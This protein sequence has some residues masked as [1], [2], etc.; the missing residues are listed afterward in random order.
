MIRRHR[1]SH[2]H[3]ETLQQDITGRY[4]LEVH[5]APGGQRAPMPY[6]EPDPASTGWG[7]S[8][9]YYHRRRLWPVAPQPDRP[10]DL[11]VPCLV[12]QYIAQHDT[13]L[14]FIFGITAA[15]RHGRYRCQYRQPVFIRRASLHRT[16]RRTPLA[17]RCSYRAGFIRRIVAHAY[18]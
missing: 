17:D 14:N 2:H 13:E 1:L 5:T 16:P 6:G 12:L 4:T 15:G 18:R 9:Q 10:G 11:L 3:R 7:R 8:R